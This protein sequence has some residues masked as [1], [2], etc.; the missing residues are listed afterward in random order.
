MPFEQIEIRSKEIDEILGKIP[1]KITRWG[2]TVLFAITIILFMGSWFFK[3]PDAITSKII[4]TFSKRSGVISTKDAYKIDSAYITS[5]NNFSITEEIQ[6]NISVPLRY[7]NYIKKGQNINVQLFNSQFSKYDLLAGIVTNVSILN[8]SCNVIVSF[9]NGI[10]IT[11]GM[12]PTFGRIQGNVKII[13]HRQRLL[14][15]ILGPIKSIFSKE[16]K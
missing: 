14:Y 3:Y 7:I 4:L 2:I 15:K 8:D 6:G 10:K 13:I 11:H 12:R 1:N 5:K 16:V 9:P